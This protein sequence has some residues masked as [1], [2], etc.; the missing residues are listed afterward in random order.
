MVA[1]EKKLIFKKIKYIEGENEEWKMN[2]IYCMEKSLMI[3]ELVDL[4]EEI[5]LN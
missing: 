1:E 5:I 4:F 3:T 2:I